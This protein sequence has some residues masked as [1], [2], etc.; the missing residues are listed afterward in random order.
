[1]QTQ[2]YCPGFVELGDG[3]YHCWREH[4]H[5][6]VA[7]DRGIAESCD[8]YFYE[9][10]KRVG[11]DR[12]AAMASRLGLG[13]HLGFDLPGERPGLVPTRSW[14]TATIGQPWAL[15]E[16]LVAGIGQGYI[17]TTPLQLAV[18]TARIVNGGRA[19]VPH[20]ARDVVSGRALAARQAAEAPS[21]GLTPRHLA[22]VVEAMSG[23]VNGPRGTARAVRLDVDGQLMGGKTGS[24][25]VRRITRAERLT[26]VRKNSD[27]PWRQRD[28]ALFVAFAPVA[29]PRYVCAVVVQHGGGG[30]AVAAPIARDVMIEVLR[31]DPAREAPGAG[32]ATLPPP[33]GRAS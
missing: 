31:R 9:V 3:R 30:S 19:V 7:L 26:G 33:G 1:T 4:G 13:H 15:G 29:A 27:L 14:K 25:Q 11:I 2:F 24:A 18:M 12:I 23:V 8:V 17:L 21:L 5:G 20:V 32:V 22:A 16:T 28:H 10:A 6:S